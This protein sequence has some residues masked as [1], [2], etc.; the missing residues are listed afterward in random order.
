MNKEEEFISDALAFRLLEHFRFSFVVRGLQTTLGGRSMEFDVLGVRVDEDGAV[1]SV[2]SFETKLKTAK[3]SRRKILREQL[4]KRRELGCF[5]RLWAVWDNASKKA[6]SNLPG[7]GT[8]YV[9]MKGDLVSIARVESGERF[10]RSGSPDVP[11]IMRLLRRLASEFAKNPKRPC[12]YLPCLGCPPKT[13]NFYPFT[14]EMRNEY[15]DVGTTLKRHA[16]FCPESERNVKAVGAHSLKAE[17]FRDSEWV[18][19]SAY[20]RRD[21]LE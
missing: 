19:S 7:C 15:P 8:L 6:S 13:P 11:H 17:V 5:D 12:V 3:N 10:Q 2:E 18:A 1:Q 16:W 20:T 14:L 21:L 4:E 9:S